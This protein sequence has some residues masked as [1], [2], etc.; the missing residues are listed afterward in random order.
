MWGFDGEM[1][2]RIWLYLALFYFGKKNQNKTKAYYH[3]NKK[4]QKNESVD[5]NV[6]MEINNAFHLL[7]HPHKH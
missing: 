6:H 7:F 5:V 4:R 2:L 3:G 1:I